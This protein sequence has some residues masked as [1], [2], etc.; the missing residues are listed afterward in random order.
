[1][2]PCPTGCGD[3]AATGKLMCPL[4]WREV[5]KHLQQEVYRTWRAYDRRPSDA[6]WSSYRDAYD[7]A[8][9]SVP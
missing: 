4:C 5:P 9:G 2:H 7:A 6:H 8:V 1:M 3:S